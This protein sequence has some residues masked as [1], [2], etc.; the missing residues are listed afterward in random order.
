MADSHQHEHIKAKLF[1]LYDGE[2]REGERQ[3]LLAHMEACPDCRAADKR[4][5]AIAGAFFRP[6]QLSPSDAFVR[7]VM[8]RLEAEEQPGE[9]LTWAAAVRWLVPALGAG[10]AVLALTVLVPR[11]E[12][13]ISTES[14]LLAQAENGEVMQESPGDDDMLGF[15]MEQP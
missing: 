9:E 8:A 3:E 11:D 15:T 4:W 5:R 14:L 6:P 2:L 1:A 12:A 7:R 13:P 10:L